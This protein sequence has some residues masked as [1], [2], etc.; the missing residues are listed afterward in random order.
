VSALDFLDEELAQLEA[1][2]RRRVP[3]V[4]AGAQG[5]R[6]VLD[7]REVVSFSSNDYLGLAAHPAVAAAARAASERFGVGAGA[8]RLIVGNTEAHETLERTAAQ[9]LGRPAAR[10]FNSGFAANTGILPVL[11]GQGDQIF[12]DSLNHASLIDGARLAKGTVAIFR[13][14]N[15]NDLSGMLSASTA[16]RRV[17]VTE[18]V[19]SMDGDVAPLAELRALGDR[20]GAILVVDEAHAVGVFGA[21]GAGVLERD[22]VVADAT[23]ATLG[24]GVG[25]YGAV[26]AGPRSLAEILWNRARPLVFTTGLPP[27]VCAAATAAIELIQSDEGARLRATL[28]SRI[29]QLVSGLHDLGI[30]AAGSSPIV[31]LI[32]GGD[33][34][35]MAWTG[36]LLERGI[37]VQGVRP[38]T[39]PEGSARLRVTVSAAHSESDIQQLLEALRA[40]L[41]AGA[42]FHVK[43]DDR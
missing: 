5:A 12:S 36:R 30:A 10:L 33:A 16:R 34:D 31:P 1:L 40:G 37:Y 15:I 11:A 41:A 23:I 24:K 26:V 21:R 18:S 17:I 39:V 4:I 8:S 27:M 43:H 9:W 2:H 19:F 32:V 3:R 13:H 28:W 25:V 22:G 38:P 20:H 7:G 42:K 6:V 14:G 35:V 29:R